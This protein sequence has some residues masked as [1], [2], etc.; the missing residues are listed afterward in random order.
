MKF[1]LSNTL[2]LLFSRDKYSRRRY[3]KSCHFFVYTRHLQLNGWKKQVLVKVDTGFCLG[4]IIV[5]IYSFY[6]EYFDIT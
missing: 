4:S 2:Q 3:T 1:N 6:M 5:Q